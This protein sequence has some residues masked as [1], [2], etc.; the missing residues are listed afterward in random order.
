MDDNK[1][2]NK[3]INIVFLT[4]AL[5]FLAD[6]LFNIFI[7]TRCFNQNTINDVFFWL[8]LISFNI[9]VVLV[10]FWIIKFL[11]SK[12]LLGKKQ[13][14]IIEK[15]DNQQNQKLEQKFKNYKNEPHIEDLANG[16]LAKKS[17]KGKIEDESI[18][19]I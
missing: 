17:N 5:I 18:G 16:F 10:I 8:G 1:I 4:I 7:F 19:L 3:V 9:V 13:N 12:E 2:N 11:I 6:V 14:N 15:N